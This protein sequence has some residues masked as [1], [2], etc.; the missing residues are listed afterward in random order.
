M[1]IKKMNRIVVLMALFVAS[2]GDGN[3][4]SESS[5]QAS[6]NNNNQKIEKNITAADL[7]D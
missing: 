7:K 3:Y 4:R 2:C 6:M 5:S 1:R